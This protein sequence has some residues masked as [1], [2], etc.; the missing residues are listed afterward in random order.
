MSPAFSLPGSDR[1]VRALVLG[2]TGFIGR[3]A[4]RALEEAG[5]E[6]VSCGRDPDRLADVASRWGLAGRRA[7]VDL[8][9]PDE[10]ERLVAGEEPDLVFNLAGYGVDRSER[11]EALAERINAGLPERLARAVAR[12]PSEWPGARV[13]HVG[14]AL[15][16][17]VSEG[18]LA[19]ESEPCPTTLYGRTKLDG[20]LRLAAAARELG[21]STVTGR[22]FTVYGAGEHAGRLLPTLLEAARD[23]G[24]AAVPLS[25]GRQQRD[26]TW[27]VD[28]VGTL[29]ELG[30][31]DGEPGRLVNVASGVLTPV[32][33]FVERA[34][35][36][37]GIHPGRLD[38]GAVDV[39]A[40]EMQHRPVATGRLRDLTGSAV[41]DRI[42]HGV[43]ATRDFLEGAG[44]DRD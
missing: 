32:R 22:L 25:E 35:S 18:D 17:G 7:R 16:Y 41:P 24:G 20:T 38:F 1:P 13:V 19:E 29:L 4:S 11:D 28:V 9:T 23:T 40:E 30:R 39:R 14:S 42:E 12:V 27:V 6:V 3:W 2:A 15:E 36:V 8:A 43:A 10:L 21:L 26:F 31:A 5:A 37:L 33:G 44:H 34:A